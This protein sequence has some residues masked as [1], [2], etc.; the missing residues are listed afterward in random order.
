MET[1]DALDEAIDPEIS[2]RLEV[3]ELGDIERRYSNGG[4]CVANGEDW[5]SVDG[6]AHDFCSLLRNAIVTSLVLHL[7]LKV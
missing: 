2:K 5:K 1:F 4:G 7:G 6:I 3:N